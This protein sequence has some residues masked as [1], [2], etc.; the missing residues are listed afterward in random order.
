MKKWAT[1]LKDYLIY[2]ILK[3]YYPK[4]K[5]I[6]WWFPPVCNLRCQQC[7]IW[8]NKKNFEDIN[9]EEKKKIIKKLYYWMSTFTLN[10]L[11]GEP[12][13]HKD[14]LLL[15]E[16]AANLGIKT[17]LTTNG[18]LVNEELARK[19]VKSGLTFIAFSLDSLHPKIHDEIRGVKGTH[20]KA[21]QGIRYLIA[22]RKQ[23]LR[24]TPVIYINSLI[25]AK[26]LE[27]LPL[28]VEWVKK[29]K[30]D[31][32]TF[33]PIASPEFFDGMVNNE[34]WFKKSRLW[35]NFKKVK[36]VLDKLI[37]LKKKGFPIKNSL[38]DLK[39]FYRYFQDP[40]RFSKEEW[41]TAGTESLT[42][43]TEGKLQLCPGKIPLGDILKDNLGR[44]WNSFDA[45][46][47]RREIARCQRQCKIIPIYKED[48]YF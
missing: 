34:Y 2:L 4:P 46:R 19:I 20:K 13:L 47:L 35:P 37:E 43:S 18:S 40:V 39:K 11:A 15:V 24:N 31:G 44:K 17:S 9:I 23:E 36:N 41:C 48:F 16:Y 14:I 45:F 21:I 27:E 1:K 6:L 25:M 28:L 3:P 8:K 38:N 33:Q 5:E 29:E 12:F 22:Y 30:I 7:Y 10:F 32:I 42:I 26:N